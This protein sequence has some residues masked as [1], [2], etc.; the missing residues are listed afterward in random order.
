MPNMCKGLDPR[1]WQSGSEQDSGSNSYRSPLK[2]AAYWKSIFQVFFSD[3]EIYRESQA[4]NYAGGM[5]MILAVQNE[6]REK[7]LQ[8]KVQKPEALMKAE[9]KFFNRKFRSLKHCVELLL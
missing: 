2:S 1:W 9:K 4:E 6:S 8:Q 5:S 3:V 7:I